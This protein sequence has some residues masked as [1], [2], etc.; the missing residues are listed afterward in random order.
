MQRCLSA[1]YSDLGL[2]YYFMTI[3]NTYL[4]ASHV[5]TFPVD[6]KKVKSMLQDLARKPSFFEVLFIRNCIKN[7]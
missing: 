4:I 6:S 1:S 7:Q 3:S 2:I 5:K